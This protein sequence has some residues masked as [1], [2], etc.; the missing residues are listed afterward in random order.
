MLNLVMFT[1]FIAEIKN[2]LTRLAQLSL[3][4]LGTKGNY[5]KGQELFLAIVLVCKLSCS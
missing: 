4:S 3:V 5:K 1:L 2:K